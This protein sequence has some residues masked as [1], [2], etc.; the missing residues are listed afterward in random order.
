MRCE[1][2][3]LEG[4]DNI[5]QTAAI[6][7]ALSIQKAHQ[8][9]PKK[10]GHTLLLFDR[11]E[12]EEKRL[13]KFIF[14]PAGWSDEYYNRDK[15]QIQLDQIVDV[16]FFGDSQQV[17]L[18]QVADAIAFVLRRYAEIL[19]GKDDV[20]Y[21]DELEK[22][23]GWIKLIAKRSYPLSTRWPSRGLNVVQCMFDR[24]APSSIKDIRCGN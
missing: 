14:K 13:S 21:K 17:L 19:D 9:I 20:R 4:C 22:L 2:V 12:R 18:L 24:L 16:P 8:N 15:K 10:K 6:H 23:K 1:K 3:L 5:W 7:I 11:E